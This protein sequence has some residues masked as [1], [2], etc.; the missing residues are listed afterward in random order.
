ML[1]VTEVRD[2]PLAR[3]SIAVGTRNNIALCL[4]GPC[5]LCSNVRVGFDVGI[6]YTVYSHFAYRL[7]V[8]G[9]EH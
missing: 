2:D 9:I 1:G 5:G 3:S 6:I 4:R 8:V 7:Q